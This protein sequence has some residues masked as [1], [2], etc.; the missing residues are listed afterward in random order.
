[1]SGIDKELNEIKHAVY[2]KDVRGA[3]HDGIEKAYNDAS[4]GG[5]A[6]M[7]VAK[8]RG[9]SSTLGGRLD[10]MDNK[11]DELTQQLAHE[12]SQRKSDI[13]NL[14][15]DKAS[16]S[17]VQSGLS[18]KRDKDVKITKSDYDVG[19]DNNLWHINDTNE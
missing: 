7:E 9:T 19:Q 4:I 1:M 8:A 10:K 6:N 5:N 14:E 12:I 3:I 13:N 16:K 17:E 18:A 15:N 2:G 11:D